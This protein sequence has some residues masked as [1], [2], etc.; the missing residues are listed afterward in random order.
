MHNH[1][2]HAAIS[3]GIVSSKTM[4]NNSGPKFKVKDLDPYIS[5][6]IY[7]Q[8]GF[9]VMLSDAGIYLFDFEREYRPWF[10]DSYGKYCMCFD[11]SLGAGKLVS[12]LKLDHRKDL[13]IP[14]QYYLKLKE[15]YLYC[16]GIYIIKDKQF[17]SILTALTTLKE[18]FIFKEDLDKLD[19]TI[20]E[21]IPTIDRT[22]L[23]SILRNR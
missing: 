22:T 18:I 4:N 9:S 5:K 17:D 1:P 3:N 23:A 11:K 12:D 13:F 16:S 20:A 19:N 10:W 14:L 2:P 21:K 6:Y 7:C 15:A 8:L